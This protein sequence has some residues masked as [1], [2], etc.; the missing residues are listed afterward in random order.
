MTVTRA[1]WLLAGL[2]ASVLL[3]M[4]TLVILAWKQGP[5][6]LVRTLEATDTQVVG[7]YRFPAGFGRLSD[8]VPFAGGINPVAAPVVPVAHGPEFRDAE[9]V[10]AQSP[11]A[12]TLQVLASRDE[13][14]VK[15]FLAG[16]ENR[17]DFVYFLHPQD[18]QAW[19]VVTTGSY[20]SRELALG[21]ADTLLLPDGAQ[22]FPRSLST[23]QASLQT[24]E[25]PVVPA[26]EAVPAAPAGPV[27][28]SSMP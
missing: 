19:Y 15:R 22:S 27:P 1:P 20:S 5:G 8:L 11:E 26:A 4:V 7:R 24:A 18:G 2:V 16:L 10:K 3:L 9:W 6:P 17:G 28:E 12:W 25:A 14:A 13:G 23:Y 21:V